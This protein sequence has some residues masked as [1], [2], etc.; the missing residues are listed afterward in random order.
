[1]DS[2]SDHE[3]LKSKGAPPHVVKRGLAGLMEDWEKVVASIG[4][5][6]DLGLDDYLNDMDVRQL[7]EETLKVV[8]EGERQKF[9]E[10]LQKTDDRMRSFTK[11]TLKCLWGEKVAHEEGWNREKNWW[12]YGQPLKADPEFLS[13]IENK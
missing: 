1:M 4:Q 6:Y 2:K 12:Y 11:S 5:G 13:E 7:L 8:S 10:R 9:R 3:Y